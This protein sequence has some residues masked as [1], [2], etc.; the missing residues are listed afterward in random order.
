MSSTNTSVEELARAIRGRVVD[1]GARIEF[2]EETLSGVEV[3]AQRAEAAAQRATDRE[4]R[5]R[6]QLEAAAV[7]ERDA[8]RELE[9]ARRAAKEQLAEQRRR[10][11]EEARQART[12]ARRDAQTIHAAVEKALPRLA[13]SKTEAAQALGVSVD[14]FDDHIRHELACIRRG[15]RRLYPVREVE[16]WLEQAA[17]RVTVRPRP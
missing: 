12:R 15:R 11:A 2:L 10:A 14:F 8:R 9:D 17:E 7:R 5:A 16:R 13:L 1:A 4:R 3:A 6:E